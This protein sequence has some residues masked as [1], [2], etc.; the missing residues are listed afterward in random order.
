MELGVYNTTKEV[1]GPNNFKIFL[2]SLHALYSMSPKNKVELRVCAA[3][4][5]VQLLTIGKVLHTRRRV[6]SSV[7]TVRAVWES[8][9]ALYSHFKSASTDVLRR[10]ATTERDAN[11]LDIAT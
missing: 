2:D 5:K 10:F 8:F 1:S 7:R 4:L 11:I 3:A 9:P 6:A